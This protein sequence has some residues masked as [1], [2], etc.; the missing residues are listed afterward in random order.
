MSEDHFHV[1]GPHEHEA[2]HQAQHDPFAG[3]IAV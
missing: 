3:R 2:E 1:H